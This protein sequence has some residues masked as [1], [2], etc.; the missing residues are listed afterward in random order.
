MWLGSGAPAP[1]LPVEGATLCHSFSNPIGGGGVREV[2]CIINHGHA[3]VLH[4]RLKRYT[5]DVERKSTRK[6]SPPSS[7]VGSAAD[8]KEEV[9]KI[10]PTEF[11][12]EKVIC[13][14]FNHLLH[15]KQLLKLGGLWMNATHSTLA[16]W[17]LEQIWSAEISWVLHCVRQSDVEKRS[18]S[19]ENPTRLR[20]KRAEICLNQSRQT[21]LGWQFATSL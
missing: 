12:F 20:E 21:P 3:S 13:S 15:L 16:K 4:W 5:D 14:M 2:S 18:H 10:R 11:L 1:L 8:K 17:A 6:I 7:I 9:L 19:I